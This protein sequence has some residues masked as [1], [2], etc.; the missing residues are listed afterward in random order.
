MTLAGVISIIVVL[1]AIL[2]L[3]GGLLWREMER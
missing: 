2:A 1:S 3:F